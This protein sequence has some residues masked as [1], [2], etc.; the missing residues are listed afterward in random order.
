MSDRLF[1]E[2]FLQQLERTSILCR[3]AVSGVTQGERRSRKLGQSVEFTDYR[4]YVAG[5]DFRRIDWYAFAR[6]ARYFLKLFLE[7]EDLTVHFILDASRSMRWGSP[8]KLSYAARAAGALGYIALANL[9]RI[10]MTAVNGQNGHNAGNYFPPHRGKRQA[11][12]LFSFLL[13]LSENGN[14]ETSHPVQTDPARQLRAYA[15]TAS[16]AGML[17]LI[18]DLMDDGWLDGLRAFTD[19]R[20]EISVIHILAPDEVNPSLSGEFH[21]ID[22]EGAPPVELTADYETLERYRQNLQTWQDGLKRFC[23]A[24]QI[25]YIPVQTSF[26]LEELLFNWMRRGGLL[27]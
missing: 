6:M 20:F 19:R 2:K 3:R 12:A 21:L 25:N 10:T 7:E 15:S 17:V 13:N 11:H 9:D 24:R 4:P 22:S 1:D 27:Q 5:D 16:P 26:P 23:A 8:S 18:S 14:G